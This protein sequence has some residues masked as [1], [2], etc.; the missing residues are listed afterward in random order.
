VL[1]N[2]SYHSRGLYES[3]DKNAEPI[4]PAF[5]AAIANDY[6][7]GAKFMQGPKALHL[8]V[9]Y[10]FLEDVEHYPTV[11]ISVIRTCGSTDYSLSRFLSL[12]ERPMIVPREVCCLNGHK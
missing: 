10:L 1:E 12:E 7:S 6:F 4:D 2:F 9:A 8:K 5:D 3:R 11:P